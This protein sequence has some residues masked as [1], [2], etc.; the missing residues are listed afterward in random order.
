MS[1]PLYPNELEHSLIAQRP[2]SVRGAH[3][4][5]FADPDDRFSIILIDIVLI[6][7]LFVCFGSV[8]AFVVKIQHLLEAPD[9]AIGRYLVPLAVAT[10]L[11]A[12]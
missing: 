2:A 4:Q 12:L 11:I 1:R 5:S 3:H 10:I 9:W 6:L 7:G 8:L